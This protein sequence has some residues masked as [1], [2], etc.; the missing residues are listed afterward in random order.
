MRHAI[1]R[2]PTNGAFPWAKVGNQLIPVTWMLVPPKGL[3]DMGLLQDLRDRGIYSGYER[4]VLQLEPILEEMGA[5]GVPVSPARHAEVLA[6]LKKAQRE[7]WDAIQ[8][9]SR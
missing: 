9:H 8:A 4:Y 2:P 6:E 3:S 7:A 1:R 5:R